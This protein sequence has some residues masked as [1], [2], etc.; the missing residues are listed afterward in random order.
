MSLLLLL[1]SFGTT[2]PQCLVMLLHDEPHGLQPW[3]RLPCQHVLGPADITSASGALG[4]PPCKR[5][6]LGAAGWGEGREA[7]GVLLCIRVAAIHEVQQGAGISDAAL[8][9][10]SIQSCAPH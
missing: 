10:L 4:Q 8:C 7:Q 2:M 1:H 6:Q 3:R 5:R 9:P